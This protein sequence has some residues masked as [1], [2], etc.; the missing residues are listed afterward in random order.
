[1][2]PSSC[3]IPGCWNCRDVGR[4]GMCCTHRSQGC[5][6]QLSAEVFAQPNNHVPSHSSYLHLTEWEQLTEGSLKMFLARS[7]AGSEP[8]V[9]SSRLHAGAEL[10]L[11]PCVPSPWVL[12]GLCFP[13]DSICCCFCCPYRNA[14]VQPC[15]WEGHFS[16][17]YRVSNVEK[18]LKDQKIQPLTQHCQ[19]HP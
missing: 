10:L 6:F 16:W 4:A 3:C 15:C 8:W 5:R 1:M 9:G 13:G 12:T 7:W 11:C 14:W 18:T 2:G 19:S 17:N